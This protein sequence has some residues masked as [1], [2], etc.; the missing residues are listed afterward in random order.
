MRIKL[1]K[2]I[3]LYASYLTK[4]SKVVYVISAHIY[5]LD[6]FFK[7][8]TCLAWREKNGFLNNLVLVF[9]GEREGTL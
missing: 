8:S 9:E 2:M 7:F 6:L 5:Y 4:A 1:F 3:A